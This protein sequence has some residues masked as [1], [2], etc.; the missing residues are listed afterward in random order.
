MKDFKMNQVTISPKWHI[1]YEDVKDL[2]KDFLA[3]SSAIGLLM[4]AEY[5]S[6]LDLVSL[7]GAENAP[8]VSSVLALLVAMLSRFARKLQKESHYP[9]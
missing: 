6:K 2:F 4:A 8:L 1:V 7:V 5:L 9:Q 3:A